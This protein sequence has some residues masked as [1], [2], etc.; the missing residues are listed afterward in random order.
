MKR[1]TSEIWKIAYNQKLLSVRRIE[2]GY[3]IPSERK[4]DIYQ[5]VQF[6]VQQNIFWLEISMND[7]FLVKVLDG[8]HQLGRV[9]PGAVGRIRGLVVC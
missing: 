4:R 2:C 6:F 9:E 3:K 1:V 5:N 7:P 8:R